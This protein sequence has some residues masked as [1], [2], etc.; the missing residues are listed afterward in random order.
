MK[1]PNS[2]KA[3]TLIELLVVIAVMGIL[4]GLLLPSIH[5]AR[6]SALRMSCGNNL[7]QIGVGLHTYSD[8][9]KQLPPTIVHNGGSGWI[10]LLPMLEQ[11]PLYQR[12]DFG[13]SMSE[14]PNAQARKETPAVYLCPSTVFP[15]R[16]RSQGYSSYAFSTG[17]TYYRSSVNLG[18]MV[19]SLNIFSWNR[20]DAI[21]DPTSIA[22]MSAADGSANTLLAGEL[23]FTL[24][25]V[26]PN[27]G[28]TEWA[29]GYPY[30][31]AGSMAG[32]FNS[33]TGSKFDFRTWET[34][35]SHHGPLVQFVFCDG[36]VRVLSE[37]TDAAVLDSLADRSD[38]DR[39]ADLNR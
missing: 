4:A 3:F 36:S 9:F 25:N 38:G 23:S 13:K 6:E 15:G 17:S 28:F 39:A 8:L 22:G 32:T 27:M 37:A 14:Q 11:M 16:V 24:R 21:M 19:D 2:R 20:G 5:A 29:E 1:K 10:S 18:A 31:S 34:F 30:H 26:P 7:R 35:R 33:R 12:F